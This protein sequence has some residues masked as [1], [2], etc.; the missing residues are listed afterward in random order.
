MVITST[1][2]PLPRYA[3]IYY[4][5]TYYIYFCPF[6]IYFILQ[7]SVYFADL[8]SD[9]RFS[10]FFLSSF[11]I[12]LLS[13]FHFH[14]YFPSN[15][16]GWLPTGPIN[17]AVHLSRQVERRTVNQNSER[18]GRAMGGIIPMRIMTALLMSWG[19]RLQLLLTQSACCGRT[20]RWSR[21]PLE[22][23]IT[24]VST[25]LHVVIFPFFFILPTN[26]SFVNLFRYYPRE[27]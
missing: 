17:Q 3:N 12:F 4:S 27:R 22:A 9:L 7:S 26:K 1:H 25:H 20:F 21:K 23:Y 24:I 6:C 19:G 8:T 15:V 5:H 16:I 2:F 11:T 13:F 14:I 18:N 10:L